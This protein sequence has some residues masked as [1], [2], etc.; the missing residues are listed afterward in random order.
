MEQ[1]IQRPDDYG[2][3]NHEHFN[4]MTVMITKTVSAIPIVNSG[5]EMAGTFE[6]PLM[7]FAHDGPQHLRPVTQVHVAP[8]YFFVEFLRQPLL[9]VCWLLLYP[10]MTCSMSAWVGRFVARTVRD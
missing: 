5:W 10:L 7:S 8:V 1:V 9:L 3:E 2:G 6:W 4:L